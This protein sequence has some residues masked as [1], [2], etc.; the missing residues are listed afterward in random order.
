MGLF[1]EEVKKT[2][3]TQDAWQVAFLRLRGFPGAI[4]RRNFQD[5]NAALFSFADSDDFRLA[6]S[7]FSNCERLVRIPSLRSQV[8]IVMNEINHRR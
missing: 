1:K 4:V 8:K 6:V 3:E 5:N 2:W 7:Q